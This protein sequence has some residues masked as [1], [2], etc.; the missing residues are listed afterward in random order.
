MTWMAPAYPRADEPF[1][2]TERA[3]LEGLLDWYRGGFLM[4]C[5]DRLR[6]P[7]LRRHVAALGVRAPRR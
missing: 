4:R 1:D 7:P 6:Q 5:A 2:G 3:T